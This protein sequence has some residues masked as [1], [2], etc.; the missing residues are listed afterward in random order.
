MGDE[1]GEI[2][3]KLLLAVKAAFQKHIQNP[4][5]SRPTSE[6]TIHSHNTFQLQ[7]CRI[8]QGAP[9]RQHDVLHKREGELERVR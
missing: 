1:E 9:P 5:K 6:S 3:N 8:R 2:S 7:L 4:M